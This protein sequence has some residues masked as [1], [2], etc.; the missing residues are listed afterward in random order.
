LVLAGGL[1][2]LVVVAPVSML[3]TRTLRAQLNAV[4]AAEE[5][6]CPGVLE[7]DVIQAMG[8][9]DE[10]RDTP[11]YFDHP[12]QKR[13]LCYRFGYSVLLCVYVDADGIIECS[14]VALG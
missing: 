11:A 4:S 2:G 1:F 3:F 9:P 10:T 13:L 12:V 7:S 8:R 14:L 6:A 5:Y